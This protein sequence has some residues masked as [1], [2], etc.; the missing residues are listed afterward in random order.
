MKTIPLGKLLLQFIPEPQYII[1]KELDFPTPCAL[2]RAVNKIT[3][4]HRAFEK[5]ARY[6]TAKMQVE[7]DDSVLRED[8]DAKTLL[9]AALHL[10]TQRL[11]R[12]AEAK[13]T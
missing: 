7:V 1:A 6:F 10:R 4:N 5:L 13:A 11:R 9:A 2:S 8:I 3:Y 12:S